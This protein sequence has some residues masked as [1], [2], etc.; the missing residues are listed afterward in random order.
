[1]IAFLKTI[2]FI[3]IYNRYKV[4]V[5]IPFSAILEAVHLYS[6]V[7]SYRLSQSQQRTVFYQK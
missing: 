4:Y 5:F 3:R 2:A 7:N 6:P 1:M